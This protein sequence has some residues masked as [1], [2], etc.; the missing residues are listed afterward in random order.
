MDKMR[1]EF[2]KWANKQGLYLA[3]LDDISNTYFTEEEQ[4]AWEAYQAGYQAATAEAEKYREALIKEI[5]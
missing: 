5:N 4:L 2:E 3:R 1:E